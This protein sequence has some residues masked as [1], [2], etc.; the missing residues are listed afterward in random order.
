M[1]LKKIERDLIPLQRVLRIATV[2]K[3]VCLTMFP[4]VM[5]WKEI[6]STLLLERSQ[7]RLRI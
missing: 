4:C 5:S 6:T 7:K 3:T 2:D 1:K